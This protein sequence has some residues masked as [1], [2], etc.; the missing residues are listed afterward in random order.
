[1]SLPAAQPRLASV[2]WPGGL[3][4]ALLVILTRLPL[5][6]H[7]YGADADAWR[8]VMSAQHLIDSGHY[9]PS[10]PP[11]YPLPEYT[12]ALMTHWGMG[13][14]A[15][16]GGVSMVL[17]GLVGALMWALAQPLGRGRA[18]AAALMLAFTPVVFTASLGAMDY[19][20]GLSFFLAAVLAMRHQSLVVSAL[21]LG[22]AAGSRPTYALGFVPLALLAIHFDLGQLRHAATWRRLVLLALLSGGLSAVFFL[23]LWLDV[24]LK[25]FHMPAGH[26]NPFLIAFNTTVG[27]FG[28]AGLLAVLVAVGLAWRSWRAGGL[29]RSADLAD[30]QRLSWTLIALFGALF[31]RLPD[32]ASYLMPALVGLYL[33]LAWAAPKA[34]VWTLAGALALSCFVGNVGRTAE[35]RP[36]LVWRGPVL[37]DLDVQVRR[38]CVAGVVRAHLQRTPAEVMVV[39]AEYRPQLLVMIGQ[40]L[41]DRVLYTVTGA[42]G[43]ALQDTEGVPI[44]VGARIDVLDRALR[45]QTEEWPLGAAQGELVD[46]RSSCS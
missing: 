34:M 2:F 3:L 35:G 6:G 18:L 8:V 33:L 39:V 31:I 40:P 29:S 25:L 36:T 19:L 5:L 12:A 17:S 30:L 20:W 24:G 23:P 26:F 14:P 37:Q 42:A 28:L 45:Q 21:L 43:G 27:L 32:E 44:P 7:G 22:L 10:R 15:W 41:A 1:M 38:S 46:S 4:L 13:G 9:V 11:G 16:L